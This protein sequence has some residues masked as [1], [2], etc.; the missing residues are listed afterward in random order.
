MEMEIQV[1]Q[2]VLT[3]KTVAGACGI[4]SM[5]WDQVRGVM[6]REVD[7][8][9]ARR[10]D[11]QVTF[12]G[13]DEKAMLKRHC[14]VTLVDDLESKVVLDIMPDRTEE[15]RLSFYIKSSMTASMSPCTWA[16]P[17]AASVWKSTGR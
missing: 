10:A 12:M 14:S 9:V 17:S 1:I 13:V 5:D 11:D 3:F 16:R 7:R 15:S 8:G 6:A 4:L 2:E